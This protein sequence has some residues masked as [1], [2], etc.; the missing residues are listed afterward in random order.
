MRLGL[1]CGPRLA[2]ADHHRRLPFE[3]IPLTPAFQIALVGFRYAAQP[4]TSLRSSGWHARFTS[5]PVRSLSPPRQGTSL[6]RCARPPPADRPSIAARGSAVA[7]RKDP[8]QFNLASLPTSGRPGMVGCSISRRHK[9]CYA[10]SRPRHRTRCRR[11]PV[12][13]GPRRLPPAPPSTR[14]PG[15]LDIT[16]PCGQ[17][18]LRVRHRPCDEPPDL[19]PVRGKGRVLGPPAARTPRLPPGRALRRLRR[20]A[21]GVGGVFVLVLAL[22]LVL[23]TRASRPRTPRR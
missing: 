15:S 17:G 7:V 10:Q 22:V 18:K 1:R 16:A 5:P 2:P 13:W 6:T 8:P 9:S 20:F 23:E 11:T 12:R 14:R 4:P 3:D 19:A 21:G